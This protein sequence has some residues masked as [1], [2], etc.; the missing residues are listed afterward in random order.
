VAT[1]KRTSR[2]DGYRHEDEALLRPEVGTQAQFR[3]KKPPK[4]YSYDSSLSPALDWDGQNSARELGEWLLAQIEE[5]SRLDPPHRFSE[6]RS[7]GGV[8]VSGLQDAVEQLKA[9]SGP[10][11]DWAGKAERLSFDVPT[12]PL[13]VSSAR[14]SSRLSASATSRT[15]TTRR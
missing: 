14:T 1:T 2:A 5:A 10:F 9:L 4:T 8:E 11:L 3:R 7:F 13:F 6:P 15:P 12:L